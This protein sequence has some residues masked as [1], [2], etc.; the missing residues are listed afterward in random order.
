M[1][2][3]REKEWEAAESFLF[4][5]IHFLIFISVFV[6]F[7]AAPFFTVVIHF[8]NK[9]EDQ[10]PTIS[11]FV[12]VAAPFFTIVIHF[13][14]KLG[15]NCRLFLFLLLFLSLLLSLQLSLIFSTS[16][17]GRCQLF[18]W[19][20]DPVTLDWTVFPLKDFEV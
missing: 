14:N 17:E 4:P 12:F 3:R 18:Q 15:D 1:E 13:L 8:L 16:L 11:V 9:S 2:E 10:L 7:V 5:G 6:F 19:N 20:L